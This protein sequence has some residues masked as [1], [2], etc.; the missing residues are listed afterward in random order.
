MLSLAAQHVRGRVYCTGHTLTPQAVSHA[1]RHIGGTLLGGHARHG[2]KTHKPRSMHTYASLNGVQTDPTSLVCSIWDISFQRGD[3]VFEAVRVVPATDGGPPKPRCLNLHLDRMER[4]ASALEL[5]LP[6]RSVLEGWLREAAAEGGLGGYVRTIVTRGGGSPGYGDHLGDRLDAPP[7]T[8]I[9]WQP[10]SKAAPSASK[11][12]MPL[13]APWHPAGFGGPTGGWTT[14]KW[15][16][17]GPNVHSSRLARQQGFDDA[18][19]LARGHGVSDDAPSDANSRVVLDGPNF[20][21]AWMR[22]DGTFCTPSWERLGMLQSI[23]CTL[24]LDAARRINLPIDEGIHRLDDIQQR[25]RGMWVLSTTNDLTPVSVLGDLELQRNDAVRAD[26][27]HA[28]EE[29]AAETP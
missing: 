20:A 24:A 27:I 17:Y 25:A 11:R 5:P 18:L 12:L 10:V 1:R 14:M 3:G 19:L 4:S 9:V 21:V 2:V 7:Q 6:S 28:M 22:D 26:L 8:F 23:T 29:I 13:C 15:L 16:A